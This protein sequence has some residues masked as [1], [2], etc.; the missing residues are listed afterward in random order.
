MNC[1]PIAWCLLAGLAVAVSGTAAAQNT[2]AGKSPMSIEQRKALGESMAHKNKNVKQ[3]RT[4]AEAKR[5]LVRR[6]GG[7]AT[8]QVPT[9][10]WNT[11][12]MRKDA[13]GHE[14]QVE[15]SGDATAPRDTTVE[16]LDNE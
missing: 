14:H 10:L 7:Q 12:S 2:R 15:S 9:E 6:P 16:G 1:T 8:M 3:P 5:T 11:L 13:Q 4:E